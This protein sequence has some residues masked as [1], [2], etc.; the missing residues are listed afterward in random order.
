MR[1][2]DLSRDLFAAFLKSMRMDLSPVEFAT[3]AELGEYM[4]GSASAS[5]PIVP[6]TGSICS[7]I[8]AAEPYM[9]SPSSAKVANSTGERSI[10]IDFRNAANKSRERS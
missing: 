4:Y 1:R 3:F 6:N 8:T 7:P 5:G 9:Y 10:R 2:Y